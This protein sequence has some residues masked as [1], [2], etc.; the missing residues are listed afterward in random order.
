MSVFDEGC[1]FIHFMI[2]FSP[3]F[4]A[5]MPGLLLLDLLLSLWF[6]EEHSKMAD[7]SPRSTSAEVLFQIIMNKIN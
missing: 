4:S 1:L 3:T 7:R 6:R 2:V 5:P